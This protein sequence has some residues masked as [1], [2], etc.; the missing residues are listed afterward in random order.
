ML[1]YTDGLTE[2]RTEAG[3]RLDE[4]GLAAYLAPAAPADADDL[5][6][7][8]HKLIGSLGE[9]VSD[10][11]AVLALSVPVRSTTAAPQEPW[12]RMTTL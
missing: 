3:S 12:C 10:D 11:T 8:V 9:G 1:L 5:L 4:E 7:A 6:A 2:A